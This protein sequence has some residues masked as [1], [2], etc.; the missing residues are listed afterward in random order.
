MQQISTQH[1]QTL[2]TELKTGMSTSATDVNLLIAREDADDESKQLIAGNVGEVGDIILS[3]VNGLAVSTESGEKIEFTKAQMAAASDIVPYTSPMGVSKLQ[4]QGFK[5]NGNTLLAI[6]EPGTGGS[7]IARESYDGA[8]WENALVYSIVSNLMQTQ[9]AF[10]ELFLPTITLDPTAAGLT[11]TT[12]VTSITTQYSHDISGETNGAN[13]NKVSLTEAIREQS[14]FEIEQSKI[15][16]VKRTENANM[17]ATGYEYLNNSTGEEVITAPIAIGKEV[18]LLGIS[19]SDATLAKGSMDNTDIISS[20]SLAKLYFTLTGSNGTTTVTEMFDIDT[21]IYNHN[22]FAAT[23]Q[24]SAEELALNFQITNYGLTTTSKTVKGI[25]SAI[26]AELAPDHTIDMGV[27]M[28][29]S[30]HTQT[31]ALSVFG[32]NFNINNIYDAAGNALLSTDPVYIAIKAVAD[33]FKI[34]GYDVDSYRTNSNLRTVGQIL[35]QESFTTNYPVSTKVGL[36]VIGATGNT[37]GSDID[38]LADQINVTS[39]KTSIAATN[40]VVEQAERL[41]NAYNNNINISPQ[42]AG[43]GSHHLKLCYREESINLSTVIDSL[44][45]KDRLAD[46]RAALVNNIKLMAVDLYTQSG[47]AHAMQSLGVPA[48][49]VKII[50]G[51]DEYTKTLLTDDPEGHVEL[52]GMFSGKVASTLSKKVAG[53]IFISFGVF[54]KDRNSVHPLNFGNCAWSPAVTTD[55]QKTINGSTSRFLQTNP[56]FRHIVHIPVMGVINAD[57]S[58]VF[59][60]ITQNHHAVS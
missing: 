39:I 19:Q 15:V 12:N 51:C 55:V 30:C 34:V 42:V 4:T 54:G 5:D 35:T 7:V 32:L 11:I 33:S 13:V 52:G 25:T 49:A 17:F 50:I 60:K 38:R 36:S 48:N 41:R 29:G 14:T 22:N 37:V 20:I 2:V 24:G 44:S 31:S 27:K 21:N 10:G 6:E 23:T 8:I 58:K 57:I 53:R 56:R 40:A 46:I 45:S 47:Y 59:S 18:S 1:I 3:T 26:L 43:I 16:P 9:D 28:H